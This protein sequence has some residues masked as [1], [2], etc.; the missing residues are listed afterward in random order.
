MN[1]PV[2]HPQHYTK[3]PSGVEAIQITEWFNFNLG[4]AI[5]YIW[6]ADE[7]DSPM[8]DLMKA[9]WYIQ[10]EIERRQHDVPGPEPQLARTAGTPDS[11][12]MD[13]Y[14]RHDIQPWH[15]V[16]LEEGQK[17]EQVK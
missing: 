1:D 13:A 14:R 3:H 12:A 11:K 15:P 9:H 2:N 7:K 17:E 6:R 5:K 4:N 10:R 8:E 16:D